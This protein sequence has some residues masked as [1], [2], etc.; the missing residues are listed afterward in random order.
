MK[1]KII[2]ILLT[3]CMFA[4]CFT[5]GMVSADATNDEYV[6][7]S[8]KDSWPEKIGTR[9]NAVDITYE[10]TTYENWEWFG[11]T[12]ETITARA[13]SYKAGVTCR[14]QVDGMAVG[15]WFALSLKVSESG[16]HLARLGMCAYG[17]DSGTGKCDVYIIPRVEK[18][19]DVAALLTDETLVASVDFYKELPNAGDIV[20][21][22]IPLKG[23]DLDS[24]KEYLIVFKQTEEGILRP[25]KL[26]FVNNIGE[27]AE[28][29]CSVSENELLVDNTMKI[30]FSAE[31]TNGN[32]LFAEDLD[33]VSYSSSDDNI[34]IVSEQGVICGVAKGNAIITVTASI[35]N[36]TKTQDIS[37]TVIE[38]FAGIDAEYVFSKV[39]D[40]WT[41]KNGSKPTVIDITYADTTDGNWEWFGTNSDTVR[42][43]AFW[44]NS[45]NCR[46]QVDS[47]SVGEWFALTFKAPKSGKYLA[48]LGI[49]T[50]G[51]DSGTGESDVYILP[52]PQSKDITSLLTSDAL[53]ASLNFYESLPN[54]GDT[55]DR[56]VPIDDLEL[57]KD[58]EYIIVFKQTEEG[59]LRPNKLVLIG[60]LG[61]L[62]SVECTTEIDAFDIGESVKINFLAKDSKGNTLYENNID[63]ISYKSGDENIAVV[64]EDGVITGKDDG[65]AT[66]TISAKFGEKEITQDLIVYVGK[67]HIKYV[68]STLDR[69]IIDVNDSAKITFSAESTFGKKL[70]ADDVDKI[71]YSTE[72]TEIISVS[73]DG[74]ITGLS[75]GTATVKIE[76]EL[77]NISRVQTLEILV[78]APIDYSRSYAEYTFK[79]VLSTWDP[80]LPDMGFADNQGRKEDIRGITY[81]HTVSGNWEWY[82]TGPDWSTKPSGAYAY[83]GTGDPQWRLRLNIAKDKWVGLTIKVPAAGKYNATLR[84]AA[85]G[86]RASAG[87]SDIYI[88]PKDAGNPDNMLTENY[89][90]GNVD[91]YSAALDGQNAFEYGVAELKGAEFAKPGEYIVIFKQTNDNNGYITVQSLELEGRRLK[92]L[93][94]SLPE[95]IDVG[96]TV[97]VS[98]VARHIDGSGLGAD[99]MQFVIYD[100][101]NPDVAT[102]DINGNVN[103]VA[104]GKAIISI[105]AKMDNLSV[106]QDVPV[107]IVDTSEVLG[108]EV[109]VPERIYLSS[110][111]T[112][113][114]ATYAKMGSG[115]RIKIDNADVVYTITGEEFA[116]LNDDFTFTALSEGTVTISA[117]TMFRGELWTS[118]VVEFVVADGISKS[119]PTMY[120]YEKRAIAQK[121]IQK[122]S[123]AKSEEKV[124]TQ[125]ADKYVNA[126]DKLVNVMIGEG[127]P[128]AIRHGEINDT[129]YAYCKYCGADVVG[130]Y[131]HTGAGGWDLDPINRP[132]KVQC[133]DC[134]RLFP[135]NDFESFMKLGLDENGRFDVEEAHRKHKELFAEEYAKA[136]SDYGYGYLKNDLYP[137]VA[138]VKTLNVNRGLRDG[139]TVEGWG[140]DDG[141][142]YIPRDAKGRRFINGGIAERHSPIAIYHLYFWEWIRKDVFPNLINAYVYTGD[143][144]YGR[145]GA[146]M[147]DRVADIMPDYHMDKYRGDFYFVGGGLAE[148]QEGKVVGRINDCNVFEVFARATDAFFPMIYD[149]QVQAKLQETARKFNLP[150]D[151]STPEQIW[152]N[153]VDG[154]LI[155]SF[156]SAKK[157]EIWGNFGMMQEALTIAAVSLDD[158]AKTDEILDF[159][160]QS[161]EHVFESTTGGNLAPQLINVVNRDG[162]GNE[163]GPNYNVEWL[164]NLLGV[165]ETLEDY[166]GT[167][168]YKLF[169]NPK[170][171]QM[172]A[173]FDSVV[174]ADSFS[175]QIGDSSAVASR[176]L[177]T[178]LSPLTTGMQYLKDTVFAKRIAEQIY[179]MNGN[180]TKDLH[181]SIYSENPEEIQQ[182]VMKYV[183]DMPEQ[184]SEILTGYGF[185]V[186]RDGTKSNNTTAVSH[187]NTLRDFWINFGNNV[188]SHAHRDNLSIGMEAYGLNFSPDLGYPTTATGFGETN[189]WTKATLSHNTVVV[190]G[191]K[192]YKLVQQHGYPKHFDDSGIVKLFDVD[193]PIAY[194]TAPI[195]R[196]TLL[197]IKVDDESSY[198]V[199][200]FRVKGGNRHEYS[201][202][203]QSDN[204]HDTEGLEITKQVDE[205][206][207]YIGTLAGPDTE[208]G[209]DKEAK[210]QVGYTWFKNIR[211]DM[212]PQNQFSVD[213]NITD[214]RKA[215]KDSKNL[216][217]K[218]TMLNDFDLS[219]VTI[220]SGHV[221]QK[222]ENLQ[223][224]KTLEYVIAE[225]SGANGLDSLFTTVLEPY[226]NERYLSEMSTIPI[227]VKEGEE[228]LDDTAHAIKVT[229]V[230]GNTDYIVYATNKNVVYTVS[231]ENATFDFS[232]F[233]GVYR[234][235]SE[236]KNIY[237]YVQDGTIIGQEIP[238]PSAYTGQILGFTRELE[239][240]NFINVKFSGDVDVN[241]LIGRCIFVDNDKVQNGAYRIVDAKLLEDGTVNLSTGAVS[242]I[243]S[244]KDNN[245]IYAGYNYNI[246]KG[247]TF[248]IPTSYSEDESPVFKEVQENV[249][250]SAGSTVEVKINAATTMEGVDITYTPENLPRGASLNSETGVLTWKPDNSQVGENHVA[251]NAVDSEG[252]IST[253]HFIITVY[254]STTGK[255][256]TPQTGNTNAPAGGGGGGGGGGAAPT[257]EK[258]NVGDSS[259]DVGNSGSDVP[260]DEDSA[261][262]DETEKSPEASGET[263]II[264]FT[265]LSNYAWAAEAISVLAEDGIIK[266]TSASTF[267][268]ASN[269]TRA[270]FAI[271]LVRAFNLESDN[272]ENFAD[273]SANDYFAKELAIARNSGIVGGIGEN[274]YA[275][276]NTITRQDMMVIVHR[277]LSK[278]GV[279]LEVADVDYADFEDVSNYA[280]DAVKALITSGLVNGKSGKIAPADYTTRA[281]VAVLLKRVI[282]LEK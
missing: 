200:F 193:S 147:I 142:G 11:T 120:T 173:A 207:N 34:A 98:F 36:V 268:P 130:T 72:D 128:R 104:D 4:S 112:R 218:L 228:G 179:R 78:S 63:S 88:V 185:A 261:K 111:G 123:W 165:A 220:A 45:G 196:R 69:Q 183:S 139:E 162:F 250:T 75:Y 204:I 149:N 239:W 247:Q 186:L 235:N 246:E 131:G 263:D 87:T 46:M 201:F 253:L 113:P 249:S 203:A 188:E 177:A 55:A 95:K 255:P 138:E 269:I 99:E 68:T 225:H 16:K 59:I 103:G 195:Y 100:T 170:Y 126:V 240:E 175:V 148:G 211:Y 206:G 38:G 12:S 231:D 267:S 213:F 93:E 272:T 202:H 141:Y 91:Y 2:S 96:T 127:I 48:R 264:R 81:E 168:N 20:D 221:P 92:G 77:E 65:A 197:M 108:I 151:K 182:D 42:A 47:M 84:Y 61:E 67:E 27:L 273:V 244:Y 277:A 101:S 121:N 254:G 116:K 224:P 86:M 212:N 274:K 90:L 210:Y 5:P 159:V 28:I 209:V 187:T 245:N 164:K 198:G 191:A 122:Y 110:F 85:Y 60:N 238:K 31:D 236:G 118:E 248:E 155:E 133:P 158:E 33:Y 29:N 169:D 124:A 37:V 266:G 106:S 181:Y 51:T 234:I 167:R 227:T 79:D 125:A 252:R 161:G 153:W 74:V 242:V 119:E 80:T 64:S 280:K 10:Y 97:P 49:C 40:A 166:S 135:S 66:I 114:V 7:S 21:C 14:L 57:K 160:F 22:E 17:T 129:E 256:E 176:E 152:Q 23:V 215:I 184:R 270:D 217:L 143:E 102:V 243:R 50:Y 26:S 136:G 174:L 232:G 226:K 137:E 39:T 146:I 171:A 257:D 216:H 54:A 180:A 145:A 223:M 262:S 278:M 13:F 281:E 163:V 190:N 105:T 3:F 18:E 43:R 25:N 140:V 76:A 71:T 89:Y 94:C 276:K 56:V 241:D 35:G 30:A 229:Y 144:K 219:K 279:N 107:T 259:D 199:D 194:S 157:G 150:N 214:F 109:D 52:K 62:K 271:L 237:R 1:K 233:V 134:K 53:V 282:S 41:T 24:T 83:S 58:E 70:T 8:I 6:F 222:K 208:F 115:A 73:E 275:P 154:I 251:V 172:F 156:E 205:N 192:Q 32:F 260:N 82:G 132:W 258:N 44:Y 265:D 9:P 117:E 19:E 230:N 189:D 15:E 178:T